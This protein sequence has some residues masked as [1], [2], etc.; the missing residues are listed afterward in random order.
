MSRT[1]PALLPRLPFLVLLMGCAGLL[2]VP[3]SF[4]ALA[5]RDYPSAQAFFYCALLTL[6]VATMIGIAAKDAKSDPR[7][8]RKLFSLL[9]AFLV[10]P[11]LLAIPFYESQGATR[12]LTA[13]VEMVSAFT[14]TGATFYDPGQLNGAEHVWRGLV[15]WAGGLL[16]WSAALAV[17]VPLNLGGYELTLHDPALSR[18]IPDAARHEATSSR[19]VRAI[20]LMAPPYF[21]LTA[22][23]FVVLLVAGEAPFTALIHAMSTLATSGISPLGEG[24]TTQ[25]G[26]LGEA[27][28]A[29]FLIFALSRATFGKGVLFDQR[30]TARN[31]PELRTAVALLT[32]VIAAL[33][34]RDLF[35]ALQADGP[36][37]MGAAL[38][39]L[40]GSAVTALSFLTTTGFV[41]GDWA[42]ARGWSGLETPGLVLMGLAIIGG[43]AATTA[44]GLKLLRV[45]TL[46][47]HGQ[48]EVG[49]LIH[50]SSVGGAG[51]FSRHL[52][53]EGAFIAWVMFMLLVLSMAV[54]M[55]ALAFFE[56][57][58]EAALIL[59][60]AALSNTGPLVN[61]ASDGA[62]NLITLSEGAKLIF[63]IAMAVGRIETL[64]LVALFNPQFWRN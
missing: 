55:L 21:S 1:T 5:E 9:G 3:V 26:R 42:N 36:P 20:A 28:I 13:Y 4:V 59:T 35:G 40:W 11:V 29:L 45:Y 60:V 61:H 52:R 48:R 24:D 34:S 64:A 25:S 38:R 15:G 43:G 51:R 39:S 33:F 47:K 30:A 8:H 57:E 58:F 16:M 2:M 50:P 10:L 44:G 62:I 37:E 56:T 12:F 23:L 46:V 63:A 53:R 49:R 18:T 14:T 32:V 54:V 22:V 31:D 27:A 6:I 19:L 17:F 41:S 7:P